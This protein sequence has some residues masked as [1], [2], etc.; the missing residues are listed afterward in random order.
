MTAASWALC[1]LAYIVGL[2]VSGLGD[3]PAGTL[4]DRLPLWALS[5]SL[6]LLGGL[7]SLL[8]PRRRPTGPRRPLW[9]VAGLIAAIAVFY[10]QFR[11]PQPAANDVSRYANREGEVT[12]TGTIL[13]SPSLSREQRLRLILEAQQVEAD[14]NVSGKLYVT[15]PLLHGTGLVPRQTIQVRGRIY[16]PQGAALPGSFDFRAYLAQ[17]G[18]FAG[19]SGR[20]AAEPRA[21]PPGLW[22]L[23][24]QVVRAH[25]QGL[26][27]PLGPLL[28]S[29][30]LGRRAVDLPVAIRDRFTQAGLAH[31]LAASGYHV[32]LL[33]GVVLALTASLGRRT[34]L[35]IGLAVLVFYVGLTGAQPSVLRA[36]IMGS[37]A[38]LGLV[39]GQRRNPL[40]LLLVAATGLLLYNPLWIWNLGFQLSFLATLGLLVT[41]PPLVQRLDWLPP[42]LA[43]AIAVPLAASLWTLPLL[44][45]TFNTVALYGI[46]LNIIATPLVALVSLGGL[47]S[48]AV[49]LAV[50]EAGSALAW[51]LHYPV[52]LLLWLT[53]VVNGL[54]GSVL[55]LGRL[56]LGQVLAV[57][58]LL[59]GIWWLPGLR[60]RW[61]WGG[62][63]AIAL[64]ALPLLYRQQTLVQITVLESSPQPVIVVQERGRTTLIGA[65]TPTMARYTLEPFLRQ[66]GVRRL[67]GAIALDWQPERPSGWSELATTLTAAQLLHPPLAAGQ[68]PPALPASQRHALAANQQVQLGSL[69]LLVLNLE[70][71]I[72]QLQFRDQTWLLLGSPPVQVVSPPAPPTVLLWSGEPLPPAWLEGVRPTLAIAAQ[73]AIDPATRTQFQQAQIPILPAGPAAVQ[74][75]PGPGFRLVGDRPAD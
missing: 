74:W 41:V 27:S 53:A 38:L 17:Q 12:V 73:E 39:A 60:R 44:L 33:L 13:D 15:L 36:A 1:C 58:G 69:R 57:Y 70:P 23:R 72:L 35:G 62:L 40:G 52:Q 46:G 75:Q 51:L 67:A 61:Y 50:P 42:T 3:A 54:P 37:G 32:S 9:L 6:L 48:A 26:G 66:A 10:C 34:R 25:T 28:S 49:A 22:Q 24:Q 59:L 71:L 30:A 18:I 56:T 2:L 7:L 21:R 29:I 20:L 19:L 4:G 14:T 47:V 65:G 5:L 43:T 16:A 31:I 45:Y 68:A 63:M 8:I 11:Q 55:T 64:I